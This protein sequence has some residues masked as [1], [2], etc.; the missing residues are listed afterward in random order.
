[1]TASVSLPSPPAVDRAVDGADDAG[2]HR[3]GEPE[4]RADRDDRVADVELVGVAERRGV[5][6]GV[7]TLMTARSLFGS[8]P[9]IVAGARCRRRSDADLGAVDAVGAGDD[10]VVGED[11]AV[12]AVDDDAGAGRAA[13][14]RPAPRS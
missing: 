12:L 3:A 13:P 9:T 10:V 5:R 6:P 1:M 8:L 7:S 11:V 2:G 4:R 14:A